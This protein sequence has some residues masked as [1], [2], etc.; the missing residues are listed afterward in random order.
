MPEPAKLFQLSTNEELTPLVLLAGTANNGCVRDVFNTLKL[1]LDDLVVLVDVPVI[2]KLYA[3][4]I[5]SVKP[6]IVTVTGVLSEVALA[7]LKVT[8]L[9]AGLPVALKVV[10]SLKLK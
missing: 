5:D 3:P 10:V 8:V 4:A 7:G 2:I 6:L 9:P 1:M